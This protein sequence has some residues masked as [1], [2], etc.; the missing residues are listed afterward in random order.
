MP[1]D[2]AWCW[3]DQAADTFVA[4]QQLVAE[5]IAVGADTVDAEAHDKQVQLLLT[6]RSP[7]ALP[8]PPSPPR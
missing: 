7:L 6:N 2:A 1:P 4:M 3:A 5:A 8:G